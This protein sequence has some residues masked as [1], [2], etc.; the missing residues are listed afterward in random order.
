MTVAIFGA[1][2]LI[3]GMLKY[4]TWQSQRLIERQQAYEDTRVQASSVQMQK[5][6]VSWSQVRWAEPSNRLDFF[7]RQ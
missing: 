5:G 3:L 4:L 7:K 2:L 1:M 6:P